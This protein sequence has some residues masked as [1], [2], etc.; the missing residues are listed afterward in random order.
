MKYCFK[1]LVAVTLL[2]F[3]VFS[4][5]ADSETDRYMTGSD[6]SAAETRENDE[7]SHPRMSFL[8]PSVSP[9]F[10]SFC[11]ASARSCPYYQW[12][13]NDSD[14]GTFE[15]RCP[16]IPHDLGNPRAGGSCQ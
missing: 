16:C 12:C 1:L 7:Q 13:R 9:C 11:P 10:G 4:A 3:G 8:P 14:C 15:S 5:F 6:S 2:T